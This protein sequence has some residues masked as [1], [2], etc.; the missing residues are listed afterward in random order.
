MARQEY[1]GQKTALW[2]QRSPSTFPGAA[3]VALRSQA[4]SANAKHF[5]LM[6]SSWQPPKSLYSRFIAK[7]SHT[8]KD[9]EYIKIK[10]TNKQEQQTH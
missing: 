1:G 10:Q 3:G 4:G 2:S 8:K 6:L 5:D 9:C 7:N